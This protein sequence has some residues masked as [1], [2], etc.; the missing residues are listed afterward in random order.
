M[1]TRRNQRGAAPESGAGKGSKARKGDGL[2]DSQVAEYLRRNPDFLLRNSDLI[3]VLTPPSP[4]AEPAVRGRGAVV[5]LQCFMLDRLREEIDG[6]RGEMD[7][8]VLNSRANLNHQG[9]IH[10]AVLALVAAKSFEHLI[11][12]VTTDLAIVLDL[13]VVMLCVEPTEGTLPPRR[14]V[15]LQ[16]LTSGTID[17]L[18]GAR[19]T[20]LLR[21]DVAGDPELFGAAAGLVR[22]DALIRLDI[23]KAAPPT[24]LAFGSR[25]PGHFHPGQGTELMS[26]LARVL[27]VT[28]RAWLDL[29]D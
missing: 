22:S 19:R 5:D 15:G 28:I 25:Q 27:E 20:A 3:E 18:L 26:F 9:R 8:M 1:T 23:A 24:L 17:E 4:T 2:E 21:P 29:P 13:D 10:E 16:Q 7:D 12:T 6:L 14:V 11:E